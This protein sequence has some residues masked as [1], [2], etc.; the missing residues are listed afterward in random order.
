MRGGGGGW[1]LGWPGEAEVKKRIAWGTP[2]EGIRK[3]EE[4]ELTV[5]TP[6]MSRR[7][8]LTKKNYSWSDNCPLR[9]RASHPPRPDGSRGTERP[10][11]QEHRILEVFIQI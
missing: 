4:R 11:R 3:R 9:T 2:G 6:A 7:T 8:L 10:E 1:E 5:R